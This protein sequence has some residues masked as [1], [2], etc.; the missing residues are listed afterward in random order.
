M[1]SSQRRPHPDG[2]FAIAGGAVRWRRSSH[3][4]AEGNCV[5]AVGPH[6]GVVVV[7]DSKDPQHMPLVFTAA[8]WQEFTG[9]LKNGRVRC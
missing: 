7:R 4:G 3:S 8:A 1:T 9:W 5:E 2:P 6:V